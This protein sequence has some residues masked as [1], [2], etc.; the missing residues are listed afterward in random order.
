MHVL[1]LLVVTQR[2]KTAVAQMFIGGPF[3]E[4]KLV[5]ASARIRHNALQWSRDAFIAERWAK[6][7][8]SIFAR[9]RLQWSRDPFIAESIEHYRSQSLLI[10][11]N[12]AAIRSSRKGARRMASA[13]QECGFNGAA[14]RSSRKEHRSN[15]PVVKDLPALSRAVHKPRSCC[16][17][18]ST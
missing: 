6:S 14:I 5:S 17:H 16:R 7:R 8:S 13:A 15:Y 12:G 3:D 9:N 4:L 18:Q 2:H 11:F 1:G 10:G